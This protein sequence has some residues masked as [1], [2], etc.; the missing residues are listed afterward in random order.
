MQVHRGAGS[1][2]ACRNWPICNRFL[3]R[4]C[5]GFCKSCFA[6]VGGCSPSRKKPAANLSRHAPAAKDCLTP[7]TMSKRPIIH[8]YSDQRIG[9]RKRLRVKTR[10]P[11][12]HASASTQL[13]RSA[14]FS[15]PRASADGGVVSRPFEPSSKISESAPYK[16]IS[17]GPSVKISDNRRRQCDSC[18]RRARI[19][20]SKTKALCKSCA[21]V[22]ARCHS[23]A[24]FVNTKGVNLCVLCSKRSR[25]LK[26]ISLTVAQSMKIFYVCLVLF[27]EDPLG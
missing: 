19:W 7:G 25:H 16:T 26:L 9:P 1:N 18:P 6:T 22:C 4:E 23:R 17:S 13:R 27:S 5:N 14:I 2:H 8:V 21:H 11:P 24:K 3:Q 12:V 20:I 10:P 15:S